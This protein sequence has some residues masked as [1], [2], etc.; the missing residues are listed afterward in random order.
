VRLADIAPR[1]ARARDAHE[2]MCAAQ[3]KGRIEKLHRVLAKE[4]LVAH[5]ELQLIRAMNTGDQRYIVRREWKLKQARREL[6]EVQ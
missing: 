2:A 1:L 3:R 5:R 6:R 4:R